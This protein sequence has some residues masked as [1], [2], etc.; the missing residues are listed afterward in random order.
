MAKQTNT[1]KFYGEGIGVTTNAQQVLTNISNMI[2]KIKDESENISEWSAREL[3]NDARVNLKN[4]LYNVDDLVGN[5]TWSNERRG[6]YRVTIKDNADKDVMYYLEYG[7]GYVGKKRPHEMAEEAGWRYTINEGSDWYF[8]I[9]D[10]ET[11]SD[12]HNLGTTG[13]NKLEE[14]VGD[15][16]WFYKDEHG[17]LNVTSGLKAV[18]YLYNAFDQFNAPNGAYD[19]ALARTKIKSIIKAGK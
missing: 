7:T 6:Y 13:Y 14:E 17:T 16:G 4:S 15:K 9:D 11:F 3:V 10:P 19:R 2:R 18:S 1:E 5:I 12:R 8:D